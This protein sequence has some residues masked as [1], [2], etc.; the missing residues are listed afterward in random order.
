MGRD[1][2]ERFQEMCDALYEQQQEQEAAEEASA[3]AQ[4]QADAKAEADK[5]IEEAK[6]PILDNSPEGVHS[7]KP[8]ILNDQLAAFKREEA[9][10][11]IEIARQHILKAAQYL[12]GDENEQS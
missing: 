7:K 2:E 3:E 9:A 11:D 1:A 5:K 12:R 4:A 6:Q 8:T 10:K